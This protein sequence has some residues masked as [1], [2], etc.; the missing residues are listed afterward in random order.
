MSQLLQQKSTRPD[1]LDERNKMEEEMYCFVKEYGSYLKLHSCLAYA[2]T[3][4]SQRIVEALLEVAL[5]DPVHNSMSKKILKGA[6]LMFYEPV[7][8]QTR[9]RVCIVLMILAASHRPY[10]FVT[11]GGA[12]SYSRARQYDQQK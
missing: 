3:I 11:S 5:H 6:N 10:P 9:L 7:S 12:V 1:Q 4:Q 2:A 8:R